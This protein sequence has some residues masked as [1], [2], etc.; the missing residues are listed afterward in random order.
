MKQ[1][2]LPDETDAYSN[3]FQDC[4][5]KKRYSGLN[6]WENCVYFWKKVAIYLGLHDPPNQRCQDHT[7]NIIWMGGR[8]Y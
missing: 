8:L 3:N 7:E 1:L 4:L 2:H 6:R 5:N